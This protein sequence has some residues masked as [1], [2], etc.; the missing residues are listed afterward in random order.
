MTRQGAMAIRQ[1]DQ[2]LLEGVRARV[3][4]EFEELRAAHARGLQELEEG[5]RTQAKRMEDQMRSNQARLAKLEAK[6]KQIDKDHRLNMAI[7]EWEGRKTVLE[8]EWK[9]HRDKSMAAFEAKLQTMAIHG[10]ELIGQTSAPLFVSKDYWV[11]QR[12]GPR[13]NPCTVQ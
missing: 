2:L 5:R 9:L 6:R 7:E 11:N 13:P 1:E 12:L 8:L 10:N 4:A 3:N